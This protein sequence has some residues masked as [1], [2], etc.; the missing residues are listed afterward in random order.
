MAKSGRDKPKKEEPKPRAVVQ[1]ERLTNRGAVHCDSPIPVR[2]VVYLEVGDV[3]P[4]EARQALA[5]VR[6]MHGNAFH[7]TYVIPVRDGKLRGDIIFEAEVLEMV[8][9]LCEV[10]DGQIVLRGGHQEIDLVRSIL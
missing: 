1:D 4:A 2:T 9:K 8:K 7:P 3:P 6:Q 5:S 10:R